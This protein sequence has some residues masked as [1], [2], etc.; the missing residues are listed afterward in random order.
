MATRFHFGEH[1]HTD[2]TAHSVNGFPTRTVKDFVEFLHALH[3]SI[4][5]VPKPIPI[6]SCLAARPA[7][8]EF[9]QTAKP[10]PA[11]FAKESFY[12]VNAY[13]VAGAQQAR[14]KNLAPDVRGR[15]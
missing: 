3:E 8:L 10:L 2:I 12:A 5:E 11:S 7:A 4:P 1:V 14:N 6:E 13:R 9:V 15:S